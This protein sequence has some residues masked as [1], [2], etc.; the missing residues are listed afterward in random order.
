MMKSS[1]LVAFV[2]VS[3]L[4][5]PGVALAQG[6]GNW[7]AG[8]LYASRAELEAMVARFDRETDADLYSEAIRSIARDEADLIR[9]RLRDG[10]FE[11]GDVINLTVAG[12]A[13]L[14]NAFTVAP[15]RL[16]ILPDLPAMP[17]TGLLRYEL[18]DSLTAFIARYVRDPTVFIT[19]T[20]RIQ[21]TGEI[22]S[23]GY[24]V[25]SADSRL[26]DI[27]ATLGQPT[28]GADIEKMVIKRRGEKIW[29]GEALQDAMVEGRTLDQLSLRAGDVIDIP[30]N[31][32]RNLGEI[33]RSLYYLVPL[34]FAIMRLF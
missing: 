30:S 3:G 29:E 21:A 24:H 13:S 16:L 14:T 2:F 20:M 17:L 19:T 5:M 4:S 15:G 9:T 28:G 26:P 23:P 32:K 31:Q 11:V 22:G 25:V 12:Q 8:Q 7:E 10:D 6:S 1:I 33:I 18:R 27:I 34:S